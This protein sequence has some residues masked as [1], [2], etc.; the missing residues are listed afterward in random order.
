MHIGDFLAEQRV[1]F[2]WIPH[3]PAFTAHK[4]A[5]YLGVSGKDVAKSV[6]LVGPSGFLLA[7]LPATHQVDTAALSQHFEG[8]VRLATDR[9]IAEVFLDCEWGVVPPFGGRYGISTILEEGIES[10]ARIVLE[11]HTQ[12]EAVRLHCRDFERLEKPR[13]L[14]FARRSNESNK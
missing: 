5:K 13:R 7:V 8:P 6:L 14:R 3:P 9:E 11:T 2:E 1:D 10:D 12:F 4:R